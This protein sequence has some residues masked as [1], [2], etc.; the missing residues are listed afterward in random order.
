MRK[1]ARWNLEGVFLRV[2]HVSAAKAKYTM[3]AALPAS[4][5][6]VV[7]DCHHLTAYPITTLNSNLSSICGRSGN[8]IVTQSLVVS[9]V[10][11]L[12]NRGCI[13]GTSSKE[14]LAIATSTKRCNSLSLY[15]SLQPCCGAM[16]CLYLK[17]WSW[18]IDLLVKKANPV[19]RTSKLRLLS[20]K[21]LLTSPCLDNIES[22][23]GY[24][25]FLIV[26]LHRP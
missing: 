22:P 1:W 11:P 20:I 16:P 10:K 5:I 13:R 23:A 3:T 7:A 6:F 19:K 9:E 18:P 17:R 21:P 8:P 26:C 12:S 24:S 4:L 25:W 14:V 2:A 15:S